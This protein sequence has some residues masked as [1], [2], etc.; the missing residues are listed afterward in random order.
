MAT[1][2]LAMVCATTGV[3]QVRRS[4]GGPPARRAAG[5]PSSGQT[6]AAP[7]SPPLSPALPEHAPWTPRAG[8]NS[9]ES[10]SAGSGEEAAAVSGGGGGA[11]ALA[12]TPSQAIL[13][14]RRGNM[15][16]STKSAAGLDRAAAPSFEGGQQ[17][18]R[19]PTVAVLQCSDLPVPADV[20]FDACPGDL[21]EVRL[22]GDCDEP[23]CSTGSWQHAVRHLRVKVVVALG[24]TMREAAST[25]ARQQ[26]QQQSTMCRV[27]GDDL[28]ARD[29]AEQSV[30][31][32]LQ[33]MREDPTIT[34][35]VKA[36]ELVVT[37]AIFDGASGAV[38]FFGEVAA[39]TP[40]P[41]SPPMSPVR[42]M[43]SCRSIG[44]PTRVGP[45]LSRFPWRVPNDR[46]TPPSPARG[47]R[48]SSP[49]MTRAHSFSST[50]SSSGLLQEPPE[51][52]TEGKS[53]K[54]D[55]SGVAALFG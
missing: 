12:R 34:A 54:V 15:R 23:E 43:M 41:P 4:M 14:L 31:R 47:T 11:W 8:G 13:E 21:I 55:R 42:S 45:R 52:P 18:Q 5:P 53:L 17:Q 51:Q 26:H 39:W 32:C 49:A 37:G 6:L 38:D 46:S 33:E 10:P 1:P 36:G 50:A 24:N 25:L 20:V 2:G 16:F 44:T 19:P 28:E 22:A 3:V 9:A 30:R 29:M 7:A 40:P 27:L 48:S 35:K